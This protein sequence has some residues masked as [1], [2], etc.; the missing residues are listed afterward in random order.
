MKSEVDESLFATDVWNGGVC[1]QEFCSTPSHH[2][3]SKIFMG[4]YLESHPEIVEGKTVLEL[5]AAA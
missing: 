2:C 5:G 4:E 1:I 3:T